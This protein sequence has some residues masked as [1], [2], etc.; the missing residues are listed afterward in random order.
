M[1]FRDN[2]NEKVRSGYEMD[3]RSPAGGP[4]LARVAP[5]AVGPLPLGWIVTVHST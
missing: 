1:E 5:L 3:P 4:G 2:P